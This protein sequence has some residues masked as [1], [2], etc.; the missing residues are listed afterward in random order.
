MDNKIINKHKE[1]EPKTEEIHRITI[2]KSAEEVL[3]AIMEPVND[4]FE[5]GKVNRS[6]IT[7]WILLRFCEDY[8]DVEIKEIR[9]ENIDEVAA[10]EAI[11][12]RAK[13]SGKMPPELKALLHKQL[14]LEE[15][16]KKRKKQLPDHIINDDIKRSAS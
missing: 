8:S 3:T 1:E 7:N 16:P 10:L 5:G 15:V 2:S 9:A 14:G 6:Q 13:K 11:L 12:R 4:G